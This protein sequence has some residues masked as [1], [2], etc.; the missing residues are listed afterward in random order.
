MDHPTLLSVIG[1][2]A[3]RLPL[4]RTHTHTNKRSARPVFGTKLSSKQPALSRYGSTFLS[5]TGRSWLVSIGFMRPVR[6]REPGRPTSYLTPVHIFSRLDMFWSLSKC[7]AHIRAGTRLNWVNFIPGEWSRLISVD[8][9][10]YSARQVLSAK[11]LISRRMEL[12]IT[13]FGSGS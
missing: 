11:W 7:L 12:L 6:W 3:V 1:D 9:F 13:S 2:V 8:Y 5:L 10:R 4:S